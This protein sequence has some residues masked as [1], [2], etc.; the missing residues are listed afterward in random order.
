MGFESNTGLGVNNFYG[1]RETGGTEGII[2]TEGLYNEYSVA[3]SGSLGFTFPVLEG[4]KVTGIDKTYATGTVSAISI[5][6]VSVNA[7]SEASPVTIPS[8]NTGVIAQTGG[9]GGV[10]IVKFKRKA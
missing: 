3:L 10:V 2:K 7:A 5:G 9:T 8:T 4:V 6:G 1:A